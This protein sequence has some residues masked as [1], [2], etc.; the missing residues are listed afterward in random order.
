MLA[1][2]SRFGDLAVSRALSTLEKLGALE[3]VPTSIQIADLFSGGI[4]GL[5]AGVAAGDP[6]DLVTGV[7][8][9][10]GADR[11]D[12]R[13]GQFHERARALKIPSLSA[14]T[15]GATIA[16]IADD[17]A[18]RPCAR[19]ALLFD[20]EGW[21]AGGPTRFLEAN[22][23]AILEEPSCGS[24]PTSVRQVAASMLARLLD[25][26]AERPVPGR[27]LVLDTRRWRMSWEEYSSHPGCCCAEIGSPASAPFRSFPDVDW[28]STLSRRFVPLLCMDG[29]RPDRPAKVLFRRSRSP[30]FMGEEAFGVATAMGEDAKLRAVAEGIERFAMLHAPPDFGAVSAA[31][32][33]RPTLDETLLR[34]LLFRPEERSSPGFRLPG[35]DR[36]L[37]LDWS[38]TEHARTGRR[39]LVPA[40]LIGRPSEG[41]PRLVDAT[42]NG[43]AA[44]RDRWSAA[45]L[46]LLEVV[47]RDA[48]LLAWYLDLELPAIDICEDVS[49]EKTGARVAAFLATQDIELPVVWLLAQLPDGSLRSASGAA[50]SFEGAWRRAAQELLAAAA[51]AANNRP[52]REKKEARLDDASVLHGPLDHL[53][54]YQDPGLAG[55]AFERARPRTM[56]SRAEL[57]ERWPVRGAE[58][59]AAGVLDAIEAA[60]LEAWLSDRSLP[61]IFGAGWHVIRALIP[62]AVELSWGQPYRRLSSPRLERLLEQGKRLS[63]LP[64]PIA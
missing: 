23:A 37:P 60:G 36:D 49:L 40:S 24:D 32:L 14:Y 28:E 17:G 38:W 29:G 26:G 39:V 45:A 13:A 1:V 10:I 42:S 50:L 56:L 44:H 25:A 58:A 30:W 59:G 62:G 54:H 33:D 47:E 31:A 7:P 3:A 52:P 4:L 41:S 8:I 48:V 19:C 15:S 61:E 27:A 12:E 2:R 18:S 55:A 22:R 9:L 11:A 5:V 46:A 34:A 64:H 43:Y 35:F 6:D 51:T 16:F 57:R 21:S 20:R 63:S 53:R